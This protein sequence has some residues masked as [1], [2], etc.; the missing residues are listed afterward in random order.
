MA[1]TKRVHDECIRQKPRPKGRGLN[2]SEWDEGETVFSVG[3][4]SAWSESGGN[5][6]RSGLYDHRS[7]LKAALA[8]AFNDAPC[9]IRST[10]LFI[11]DEVI[12]ATVF[13]FLHIALT[14]Q[15]RDN[16]MHDGQAAK[17]CG[18]AAYLGSLL[19]DG[20]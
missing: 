17:E 18:T 20:L 8:K 16:A 9:I 3:K 7:G 12:E 6:E 4:R 2:I 13:P 15:F 14:I 5:G 19:T 10:E 11:M 1:K